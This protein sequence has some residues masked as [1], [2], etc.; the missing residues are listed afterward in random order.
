MNWFQHVPT[1]YPAKYTSIGTKPTKNMAAAMFEPQN[2]KKIYK[3]ILCS[4]QRTLTS[5]E[6]DPDHVSQIS[7][8]TRIDVD[9][10]VDVGQAKMN[11]SAVPRHDLSGTA[12]P[13]CRET[14]RGGARGVS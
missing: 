6:K 2:R 11:E 10:D 7:L 1:K 14:A 8:L 4:R 9:V 3:S 12:S 5:P 13:D